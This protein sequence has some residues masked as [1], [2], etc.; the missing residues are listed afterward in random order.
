MPG[1]PHIDDSSRATDVQKVAAD[2]DAYGLLVYERLLPALPASV[3]RIRAELAAVLARHRLAPGRRADI[4]LV[5]TEAATNAVW[6]AYLHTSPGPL[7]VAVGLIRQS[8]IVAVVDRGRGMLRRSDSP[9]AGL[10]LRLMRRLADDLRLSSDACG[11][12]TC[13]QAT[14]DGAAAATGRRTDLSA[15]TAIVDRGEMLRYYLQ[16]LTASTASLHQDARASLAEA[17]QAV[18]HAQRQQRER[19]R[20]R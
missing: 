10:G 4:L 8:L 6:H 1:P 12:G 19:A 14:F 5:L 2:I 15:I 3:G 17:E 13:V 11:T 7:Y 18:A 9:G 16:R 20:G